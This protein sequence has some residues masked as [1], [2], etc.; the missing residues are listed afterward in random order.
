MA[1]FYSLAALRFMK[2]AIISGG[3]ERR[4]THTHWAASGGRALDWDVAFFIRPGRVI[5]T[6]Y[7][8]CKLGA[9]GTVLSIESSWLW[10]WRF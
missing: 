7:V 9:D 3:Q 2:N 6:R 1:E 8:T 4:F 5:A 10:S